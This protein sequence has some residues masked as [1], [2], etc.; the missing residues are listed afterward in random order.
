MKKYLIF[1]LFTFAATAQQTA[2]KKP[3]QQK[4]DVYFDFAKYLLNDAAVKKLE[5]FI[6]D[7]QL[8][9]NKIYGYCDWVGSNTFNDTLSMKRV[10]EVYNFLRRKGINVKA[11]FEAKGFGENFHQSTEQAEN[12]RVTIVFEEI[13][14][15]AESKDKTL[16]DEMKT[17]KAGD[18]IKLKNINFHN[19]SAMIVPQSKP[20]LYELLCIMEENPNLKIEIQGHICCQLQS[21]VNDVSTARA[22]AIYNFLLRNK[23]P[24]KRLSYIGFG[25]SQPIHPIPEKTEEE[26]NENRRVEIMIVEN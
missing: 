9:V 23:I 19:N 21:D 14:P 8:S 15:P 12:R 5:D 2:D 13:K 3:S 4:V 10:S 26:A 24:R 17:L 6:G 11:D 16:T 20:I 22:R 1:L 25:V 7:R 18:K